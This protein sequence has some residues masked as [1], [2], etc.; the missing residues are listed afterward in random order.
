MRSTDRVFMVPTVR[1]E[2]TSVGIGVS[3]TPV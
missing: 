1:G 2:S 3:A